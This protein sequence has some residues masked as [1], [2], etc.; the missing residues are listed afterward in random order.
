MKSFF[1]GLC[2]FVKY[3]ILLSIIALLGFASYVGSGFSNNFGQVIIAYI[4]LFLFFLGI[5][6]C[7]NELFNR[8]RFTYYLYGII[9]CITN[10]GQLRMLDVIFRNSS[11][12]ITP[13]LCTLATLSVF[14]ILY[15]VGKFIQLKKKRM[16]T[17][18][19]PKFDIRAT[20][21]GILIVMGG[22]LFVLILS[23]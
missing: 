4:S 1:I 6:F 9:A 22:T 13:D 23:L 16:N 10:L 12:S 11:A 2:V 20:G 21:V 5:I 7:I 17:K 15:I 14:S 8:D 19:L 18:L 3:S